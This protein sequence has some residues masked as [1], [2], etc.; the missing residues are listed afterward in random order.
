M[1]LV[2]HGTGG[3]VVAFLVGSDDWA[4]MAAALPG[5]AIVATDQAPLSPLLGML[6]DARALAHVTSDVPLCLVGFSA[7]C[8]SVRALLLL[9]APA[10][11]VVCID[12]THASV[13]PAPWQLGVWRSLGER[14]RR[15]EVL[16]VATCTS[17][18]YTERIPQGQKGRATSTRHVLEQ[19]MGVEL[20]D[21]A[22]HVD[23]NLVL[24]R[25]PSSDCDHAAHVHQQN[26]VL[27][28]VL[29]RYVAPRLAE[30]AGDDEPDTD[31]TPLTV[32]PWL[33]GS[34]SL[35][36][37]CVLWS[38][39]EMAAG[40]REDPPGSNSGRRID[41]YLDP[42]EPVYRRATGERLRL[43]G[44]AWCAAA[45]GAAHRACARPGEAYPTVRVSGIEMYQ[46][47]SEVG[48]WVSAAE[49]RAGAYVPRVG[50]VCIFSRGPA[51]SWT[52][53]V[54]RL[55]SAWGAEWRTIGGNEGHGEWRETMHLA[56][57]ADWL[58]VIR[59]DR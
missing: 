12:G 44:V 17:M 51:D 30:L 52:R 8:Q 38:Q 33:D 47:A 46:D 53:H 24:Q 39:A 56:T 2:Q 42:P 31:P 49:V 40:V 57:D 35:G 45:A 26:D 13:P 22:P 48:A 5:V 59:L 19:S 21:Y 50:D 23:G 55:C 3:L 6:D 9:K 34:L 11:A 14:A 4:A 37:R 16:F 36:A 54:A 58:G 43:R 7:G 29:R 15:G 1:R 27:P 41:A 10:A 32:L 20:A 18:S 28:E 25:W